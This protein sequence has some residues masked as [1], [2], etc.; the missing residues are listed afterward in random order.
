MDLR[1]VYFERVD[2]S[3]EATRYRAAIRVGAAPSQLEELAA[4]IV[5]HAAGCPQLTWWAVVLSVG[6]LVVAFAAFLIYVFV[7]SGSAGVWRVPLMVVPDSPLLVSVF[8]MT[9]I[10]S[11]VI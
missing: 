2:T 4:S 11:R 6:C 9:S 5:R 3:K 8:M 7:R 1:G 10:V